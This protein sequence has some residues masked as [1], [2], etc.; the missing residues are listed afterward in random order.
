[1]ITRRREHNWTHSEIRSASIY[2]NVRKVIF[3]GTGDGAKPS[4]ATCSSVRPPSAPPY[5]YG[6]KAS[7]VSGRNCERIDTDCRTAPP[8][9][10]IFSRF[11]TCRHNLMPRH[12]NHSTKDRGSRG[13]RP[14]GHGRRRSARLLLVRFRRAVSLD[15]GC[16]RRDARR[17]PH[18]RRQEGINNLM[19]R[20]LR[21]SKHRLS[22]P[23]RRV[24]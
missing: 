21:R 3:V 8:L 15:D 5:T 19:N 1:M 11:D 17:A 13:S 6:A 2:A 10:S 7:T 16:D 24:A 20:P 9:V 22:C 4:H 12:G 18:G 14:E 23:P